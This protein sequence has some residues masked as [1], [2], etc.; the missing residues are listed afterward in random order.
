MPKLRGVIWAAVSDERQAAPDKISLDEQLQKARLW[1]QGNDIAVEKEFIWDGHSRYESDVIT[2]LDVFA[3][4]GMY[5]YHDLRRMWQMKAFDVLICHDQSRLGRSFTLQSWVIENVTRSGARIFR[6]V[7]GWIER[8]DAGINIAMGGFANMQQTEP[9][10]AKAQAT[11]DLYV[12]K[13]IIPS[14]KLPISHKFVRNPETGKQIGVIVDESKRQMFNDFAGMLLSGVAMRDIE[15]LAFERFGYGSYNK[16]GEFKPYG[17]QYFYKILHNP[18]FWGHTCRGYAAFGKGY[19]FH[20]G[21]WAYDKTASLPDFAKITYD[22]HEP[23]FKGELAERV[24]A[25]VERRHNI[26]GR[27]RPINTH[28]FSGVFVCAECGGHYVVQNVAGYVR[29]KDGFKHPKWESVRCGRAVANLCTNHKA[30]PIRYAKQYIQDLLQAYIRN[31]E[32]TI[33]PIITDQQSSDTGDLERQI[34]KLSEEISY[35][36]AREAEA[37]SED[38]RTEYIRQAEEKSKL[39]RRL[40]DRLATVQRKN[41]EREREARTMKLTLRELETITLEKFWEQ[42]NTEINQ[43]ILRLIGSR[44][45]AVRGLEIIGLAKTSPG[46]GRRRQR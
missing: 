32:S 44:R 22:T 37:S 15:R 43:F 5:H 1:A 28:A 42:S 36:I 34:F 21:A 45:F 17:V 35:L 14:G 4:R 33:M 30:L 18:I 38:L 9:F 19:K 23:M 11:K 40:V 26:F 6:I 39:K 27:T 16:K 46:N 29:K 12:Q 2:A 7:G 20:A 13:G 10:V 8:S 3:E 41:L 25:E 24:I 31:G